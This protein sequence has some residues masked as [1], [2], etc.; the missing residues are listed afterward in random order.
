MRVLQAAREA[1]VQYVIVASSSSVYGS[2]ALN[3]KNESMLPQPMSPYAVSK[4]ASEQY[5]M[6]W[7]ASFGLPT[8][9]L[10]FFNVFGP[11]QSFDSLYAAAIPRFI[12]AALTGIEATIFGDGEQTRDFTSVKYV[13]QTIKHLI[14]TRP[15]PTT[16]VNLAVGHAQ[17]V[18]SV[19]HK[20]EELT[21]RTINRKYHPAR[22]GEVLHSSADVKL[23]RQLVPVVT[24]IPFETGLKETIES[25]AR[26]IGVEA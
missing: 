23:V 6:A 9:A 20:I 7:S 17:S 1:N 13:A 16:P 14:I 22:L 5:A 3:P 12:N 8:L 25:M 24:P 26:E 10:R 15:R 2:N 18:N 19:L 4:L 21:G 11:R